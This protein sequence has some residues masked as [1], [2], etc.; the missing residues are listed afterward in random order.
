MTENEPRPGP[1]VH[2]HEVPEGER[3]TTNQPLNADPRPR[4]TPAVVTA[5]L[6]A[7]IVVLILALTML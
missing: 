3:P 2:L 6:V 4:F 1:E 5:I 7:A